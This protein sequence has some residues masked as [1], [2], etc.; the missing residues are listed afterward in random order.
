MDRLP[1][2]NVGLKAHLKF[3]F[4]SGFV[5]TQTKKEPQFPDTITKI[6]A[7]PGIVKMPDSVSGRKN[8]FFLSQLQERNSEHIGAFRFVLLT[9]TFQLPHFTLFLDAL[10]IFLPAGT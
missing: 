3:A 9:K 10:L 5:Q 4:S 7:T 8:V 1:L 2:T 6:E